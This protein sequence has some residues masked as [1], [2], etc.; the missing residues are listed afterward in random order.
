M[1][2]CLEGNLRQRDRTASTT[3][4]LNSSEIS[5]MKLVICFM[6]LSTEASLPVYDT[7]QFI[8]PNERQDTP[9][10]REW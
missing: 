3:I 5:D 1:E 9:P 6:S 7:C 4:T 8:Q 10:S 2:D